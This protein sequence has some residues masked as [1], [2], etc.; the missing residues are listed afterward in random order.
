M[1][2]RVERAKRFTTS[3]PECFNPVSYM[4]SLQSFEALLFKEKTSMY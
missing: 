3:E 2:S 4:E 1:L